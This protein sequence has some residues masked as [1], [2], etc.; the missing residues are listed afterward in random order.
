MILSQYTYFKDI[1]IQV[2]PT[3]LFMLNFYK[4]VVPNGTLIIQT[5]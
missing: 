4:Q 5:P 3:F 2:A 1:E